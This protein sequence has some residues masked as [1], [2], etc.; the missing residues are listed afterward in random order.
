MSVGLT[1]FVSAPVSG[2]QLNKINKEKQDVKKTEGGGPGLA[3][4]PP[5]LPF[6]V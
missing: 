1:V 5:A 4:F 6:S 3:S 2:S